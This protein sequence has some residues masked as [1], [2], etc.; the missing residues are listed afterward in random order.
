MSRSKL[1]LGSLVGGALIN[2]V[3]VACQVQSMDSVPAGADA[4]NGGTGGTGNTGGGGSGAAC[5][6]PTR[7]TVSCPA[8]TTTSAP[9]AVY[10]APG[11]AAS[12]L[13]GAH[14]YGHYVLGGQD[15]YVEAPIDISDGQIA[16][17]GLQ[18]AVEPI[19]SVV[20]VVP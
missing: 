4:G 20:F 9:P 12:D 2:L 19:D 11:K 15:H 5:G 6:C 13:V 17:E 7:V 14:A 8:P 1:V 3:F 18:S 10:Q 16:A